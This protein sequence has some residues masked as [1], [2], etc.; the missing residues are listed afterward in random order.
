MSQNV[1]S[2]A[3]KYVILTEQ[4]FENTVDTLIHLRLLSQPTD[5]STYWRWDT[6]LLMLLM[7]SSGKK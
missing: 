3:K 6:H 2:A 7:L 4:D 1:P 5:L